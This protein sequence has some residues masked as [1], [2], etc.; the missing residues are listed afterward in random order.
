M[1]LGLVVRLRCSGMLRK[2]LCVVRRE[3]E[4]RGRE[5]LITTRAFESKSN[6]TL[7]TLVTFSIFGNHSQYASVFGWYKKKDDALYQ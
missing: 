5:L 7:V 6:V 3:M 1:R 2:R 4:E